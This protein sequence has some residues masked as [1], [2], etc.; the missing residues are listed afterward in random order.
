MRFSAPSLPHRLKDV[1]AQV[2]SWAARFGLSADAVDDIVLATHEALAN[3]ADHAYPEGDGEAELD[4][5]CVQG[6][7]RV[8]VRD[9]GSWKS[10]RD[11]GWR[12]H[13]LVLIAGLAE[14]V[15]VQRAPAGTSIA[16]R[17]RLPDPMAER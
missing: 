11:P 15:D 2:A 3:V 17:W 13:G 9:H 12:G 1:R 16:M 5:A 7:I 14:H 6:E 8:V 10:P 4:A